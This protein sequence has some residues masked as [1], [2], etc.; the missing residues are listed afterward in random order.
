LANFALSKTKHQRFSTDFSTD[1]IILCTAYQIALF[2]N[3][4]EFA[5]HELKVPMFDPSLV[6]NPR[7]GPFQKQGEIELERYSRADAEAPTYLQLSS[8]H[9]V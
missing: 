7:L 9:I 1:F 3:S 2:T 5:E 4:T 6:K 8:E